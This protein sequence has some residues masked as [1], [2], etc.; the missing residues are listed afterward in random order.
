MRQ[1]G[2]VR[3]CQRHVKLPA[4]PAVRWKELLI[5]ACEAS[6]VRDDPLPPPIPCPIATHTSHTRYTH[7]AAIPWSR[8]SRSARWRW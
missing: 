8:Q 6:N 4:I 3:K 1:G 2:G 5:Q 7:P